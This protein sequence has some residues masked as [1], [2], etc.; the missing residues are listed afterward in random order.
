MY[1]KYGLKTVCHCMNHYE[2]Q[3]L[4]NIKMG[5]PYQCRNENEQSTGY[6]L[7]TKLPY[8]QLIMW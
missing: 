6:F 7:M 3:D 1:W 2:G 4:Y 5:A 8:G